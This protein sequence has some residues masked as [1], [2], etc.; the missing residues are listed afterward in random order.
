MNLKERRRCVMTPVGKSDKAILPKK[1]A[2]KAGSTVAESVEGRALTERNGQQDAGDQTQSWSN[3]TSGLVAVREAARKDKR[4]RFTNLLH[5]VTV[6]AL[7][8]SYLALQRDAAPGADGITW[9]DYQQGLEE[10]LAELHRRVQTGGY[11]PRPARRVY[12]PKEDGSQR[13]LSVTALE[14]K[15]VQQALVSVLNAVYEVDFLGFSYGF[16]PGRG[17]HDALDALSVGIERYKVNWIVD[18]DIR[19]FFDT[20]SHEWLMRFIEHRIGDKRVQ[21]L[22]RQWLEIGTYDEQGKR[23]KATR[24]TPQGA[25]V[26]PLLANVYLHYVMDLWTQRWRQREARAAM[27]VVRY[28]DDAVLGFECEA[29]AR[30]YLCALEQRLRQFDLALHPEKT[31]IIRFGRFAAAQRAQRGEGKLETFNFLGFTHYYGRTRNGKFVVKRKTM[32]TR[33]RKQIKAVGQ[34]LMRRRHAP[35]GIV[36]N[37]LRRVVQGHIN[38]YGVPFNGVA[39]SSFCYEVRKRWYKALC[40]RSQRRRLNWGRFAVIA[41][42]WLPPVRIV[43]PYPHQRFDAKYST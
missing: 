21:R 15:I 40:R 41:A 16:R 19:K 33:L 42:Y 30:R 13:P 36:G 37:W 9:Q 6:D 25:V 7:R 20:V 24:G 10:R 1:P 39:L 29:E 34:E 12:I 31:R 3:A 17:Q 43:H 5:H 22:I 18:L 32:V 2:N 4:L 28:A 35:V 8:S 27:M 38:Y 14:D 11:R 23:I 26:S